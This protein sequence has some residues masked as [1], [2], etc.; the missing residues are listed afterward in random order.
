MPFDP[1]GTVAPMWADNVYKSFTDCLSRLLLFSQNQLGQLHYTTATVSYHELGRRQIVD[2]FLGDWVLMLDTDHAFSPDLL[3]RML[4]L[5]Q[6]YK[7]RV[8][9]AIYQYKHPPHGP[10]ANLWTPEGKLSPLADWDRS[11]EI[12]DIGAVGAGCLLVDRDVFTEIKTKLKE[13]PFAIR[14][15]LSE[16]FSFCQRCKELNIPIGLATHIECHHVIRTNLSIQ[17][18]VAPKGL[19]TVDLENGTIVPELVK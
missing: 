12:M 19:K 8:L 4:E 18:Y 11:G 10:V 9:S 1:V 5:K 3:V 7:Y 15:G 13:D 16:D 14:L 2:S 6:K 17:D